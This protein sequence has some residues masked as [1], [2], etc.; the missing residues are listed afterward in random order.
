MDLSKII[1]VH[2]R[3]PVVSI[4]FFHKLQSHLRTQEQTWLSQPVSIIPLVIFRM[5]FG[6][7]M[8]ASTVR[9]VTNGWVREF[10]IDPRFHF[11]YRG[12]G[13]VQPLPAPWLYGVFALIGIATLC[14][15][16]GLWYR[17][18]M[19]I[20]FLLFT[21]VELLDKAY[22]LNHYYFISVLSFLLLFLPLN[23]ACS[24]DAWRRE[25][26]MRTVPQWTVAAL[27]LQVGLVYFFAG[28]AKLKPD[29]LL[30]AMPLRIWLG[31]NTDFPLIGPLFD[32]SATA[33]IMSWAGAAFDLTVPFLLLW[34]R[35]RP[36]A[37]V[38][39]ILFHLMTWRLFAIGMFPWIMMASALIFFSAEDWQRLHTWIR[40]PAKDWQSSTVEQTRHVYT[41]SSWGKFAVLSVLIP[42]FVI[43]LLVPLRHWIIPGNVLWTEEGYRF[44]WNVMLAEKTG[45][46]V[47]HLRIPATAERP[48]R[49]WAAYPG[50]YLSPQQEK[51]ISIQ[52]DMILEFAHFLADEFGEQTGSP[53]EVRAETYVSLNGRSSRLLIDPNVDLAQQEY[54][55]WQH[56]T[57]ILP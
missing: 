35:T 51:Q 54:R 25:R 53:V 46:V 8:F 49:S 20:F 10:Y 39:V 6:L 43:Q 19:G 11:T 37:Y 32:Y 16:V 26:P 24:I 38:A 31:A 57:W 47:F 1:C 41:N 12:F 17:I 42:F 4:P 34:R 50:D 52:P 21:Y 44:A 3:P 13:W 27:R 55:R 18:S 2:L 45:D 22:Y 28:I 5:A 40:I 33:Y 23:G 48:E 7:L 30:H 14:I 15:A 56:N 9:F 29:W 36:F